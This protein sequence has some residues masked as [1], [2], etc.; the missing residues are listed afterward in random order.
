MMTVM[1]LTC[2]WDSRQ[3][4]RT[5]TED[6]VGVR[7]QATAWYGKIQSQKLNEVECKEQN[8]VMISNGFIAFESLDYDDDQLFVRQSSA[9]KD[10]NRRHR[11]NP[12]Q[13]NG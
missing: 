5:Q 3:P 4:V 9:G 7:Y 2:L 8:Q 6:I 13:G 12:L 11:W 10:A 1:L